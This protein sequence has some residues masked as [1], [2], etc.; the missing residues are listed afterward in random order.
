[1]HALIYFW[2]LLLM[3]EGLRFIAVHTGLTG[4]T[5]PGLLRFSL[6]LFLAVLEATSVILLQKKKHFHWLR[7]FY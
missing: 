6:T 3:E 5:G 2:H 7:V 1:M 4:L